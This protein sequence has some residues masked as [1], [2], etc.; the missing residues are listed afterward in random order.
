MID[1]YSAKCPVRRIFGKPQGF[2]VH[3][4]YQYTS[5]DY[6][7]LRVIHALRMK[8]PSFWYCKEAAE[9]YGSVNYVPLD[10]GWRQVCKRAS[11]PPADR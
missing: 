6:M 1:I 11:F 10:Y 2:P 8:L 9:Y 4:I 5:P 3:F 7:E